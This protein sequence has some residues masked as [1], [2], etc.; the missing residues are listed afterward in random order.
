MNAN[1]I[2]KEALEAPDQ[3]DLQEH[4][5]T[6]SALREKNYSWREIADF[7]GARGVETDHTRLYRVYTK[8]QAAVIRVPP[9]EE[10]AAALKKIKMTAAQKAA[11]RFHY[12]APNR[13]VTFTE[14]SQAAGYKTHNY[15]NRFYGDLGAAIG[16]AT[17]YEFP[18]APAR[19]K[20]FFSGAIG[21]DAP[22]GPTGEY[23][24]MMHHELAKAIAQAKIFH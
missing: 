18:I 2:L 5:G 20:P 4:L 24:F 6:I 1:D 16:K 13:T 8:H 17:G 10:Y 12:E 3:V 23:R 14:L 7:L 9:A 22:K 15:A 11:L 19:G 21:I